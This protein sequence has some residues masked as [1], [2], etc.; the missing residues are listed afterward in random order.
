MAAHPSCLPGLRPAPLG[1]TGAARPPPVRRDPAVHDRRG[2][3]ARGRP[4]HPTFFDHPSDHLPGM[5]LIHAALRA[6]RPADRGP[7]GQ[8]G[9]DLRFERFAELG[10]ATTLVASRRTPASRSS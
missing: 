2:V 8:W 6:G 7:A 3:T 5:L 9:S 10:V 4:R 1:R